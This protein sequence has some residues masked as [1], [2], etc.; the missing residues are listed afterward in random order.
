MAY[1]SSRSNVNESAGLG[2]SRAVCWAQQAGAVADRR[3]RPP[4]VNRVARQQPRST[5]V[6]S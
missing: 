4:L 5:M 3:I 6:R 1:T 2:T